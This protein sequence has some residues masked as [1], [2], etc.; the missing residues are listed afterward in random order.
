M[1][2]SVASRTFTTIWNAIRRL[3]RVGD[4]ATR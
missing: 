3:A 4:L 2:P 1:S